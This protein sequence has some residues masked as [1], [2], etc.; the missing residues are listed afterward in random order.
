MKISI[1]IPML[2]ELK[3]V[4]ILFERIISTIKKRKEIFEII[5][6][7]DGSDQDVFPEYKKVKELYK[8]YIINFLILN[9]SYGHQ[10]ALET[11]I[12]NSTGD[13][14]LTMDGDLQDPPEIIDQLIDNISASDLD[15]VGT[16][17]TRRRTAVWKKIMI[18]FFYKI[19]NLFTVK[20]VEQNAGDFR[21]AKRKVYDYIF[22]TIKPYYFFRFEI[23]N[24][25]FLVKY[26]DYEQQDRINEKAKSKLDW[27][28]DFASQAFISSSHGFIKKLFYFFCL[29]FI[30][31]IL[32][33]FMHILLKFS[34]LSFDNSFTILL[35]ILLG[36]NGVILLN[37]ICFE[38]ISYK[39][40]QSSNLS[41]KLP[42]KKL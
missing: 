12:K 15:V 10:K 13:Y 21:I 42:F 36:F 41:I 14:I 5:V 29:S 1:I 3:N 6:V 2:N 39:I 11:G 24:S 8:D 28:I 34:P 9:K 35:I 20:K 40:L 23:S 25:D 37:L 18:S 16:K 26:I 33:F 22:S 7:D 17:R 32:I 27:Y 38:F 19:V 4:S 30:I 31:L